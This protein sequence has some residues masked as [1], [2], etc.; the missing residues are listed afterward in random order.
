MIDLCHTTLV[1]L[2]GVH[3]ASALIFFFPINLAP[4]RLL[5]RL[6]SKSHFPIK[7]LTVAVVASLSLLVW[8]I[9]R[10]NH[11]VPT[12]VTPDKTTLVVDMWLSA[13]NVFAFGVLRQLC[14]LCY[15]NEEAVMQMEQLAASRDILEW[16]PPTFETLAPILVPYKW[17]VSPK[18]YGLDRI[19][20]EKT[21]RL[22]FVSN[23]ALWGLEM[24]LLIEGVYRLKN[25]FLRGLGD[26]VHFYLPGHRHLFEM[27]GAVEGTRPNCRLMLRHGFNVLVY[28]GGAREVW[29]NKKNR[30]YELLWGN[31]VGFAKIAI[32]EGC[33]IVPTCS[34]G[35]EDMLEILRDIPIDWLIGRSGLSIPILKVPTPAETQRV[36]FWFGDPISTHEY[37][38]ELG[39]CSIKASFANDEYDEKLQRF[40][41]ALRDKTKAAVESGISYLQ[42]V[43]AED[44]ERLLPDR[45]KLTA[46]AIKAA[47]T[48]QVERSLKPFTNNDGTGGGT[49][50]RSRSPLHSFLSSLSGRSGSSPGKMSPAS[51]FPHIDEADDGREDYECGHDDDTEEGGWEGGPQR[52]SVDS[53]SGAT[54]TDTEAAA[55]ARRRSSPPKGR[56]DS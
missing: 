46:E 25:M 6:V 26:R 16:Q 8:C 21:H 40:A 35:T 29:K 4:K 51:S 7:A 30:K 39:E 24:P 22:L 56:D 50:L 27:M 52:A 18:F 10:L 49:P 2:F 43:Q 55:A 38:R 12:L 47:I 11:W 34:V 15:H 20:D 31:R 33:T 45:V 37:K 5:I 13:S 14:Y 32:E 23:H 3:A 19:P 54:D 17:L 9:G 53:G 41:E 1:C 44:C 36:Y 42:K 28:P 48:A